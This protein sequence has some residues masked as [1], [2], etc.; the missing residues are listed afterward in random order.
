MTEPSNRNENRNF[1]FKV[2]GIEIE[3]QDRRLSARDVL[4]LAKE[5][6]AMPND[7]ET[8]LLQGDKRLYQ[9]NDQVDLEE[10]AVFIT[11]PDTPTQVA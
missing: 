11:I 9:L 3:V 7:P 1:P 2:N 8:Y 4:I 6:G 5:R 10:D